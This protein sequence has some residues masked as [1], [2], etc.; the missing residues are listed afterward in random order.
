MI[1]IHT[2]YKAF[3]TNTRL[4]FQ[5]AVDGFD[6]SIRNLTKISVKKDGFEIQVNEN[7]Y[8]I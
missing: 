1:A 4:V 7:S 8:K 6:I 5:C 3:I 2:N